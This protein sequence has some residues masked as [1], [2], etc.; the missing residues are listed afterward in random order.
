MERINFGCSV[1]NIP[2]PKN[3]EYL[4]RLIDMTEKLIKRMRWRAHYFL[5]PSSSSE[6][7]QETFGFR[8][9]KSPPQIPELN[10]F[11]SKMASL[12]QNIEFK[13]DFRP[14]EFQKNL[15]DHTKAIGKDGKL[16]VPADKTTN[17]YTMEKKEYKGMLKKSIEKEYKKA[18]A[19]A[20]IEINKKA[21]VIAENLRIENRVEKL[22][23]K[24]RSLP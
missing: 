1:K 21:K 20:E 6:E 24:T 10:E 22:A 11:E 7:N 19:A 2:I 13:P 5:H 3:K 14:T 9:K 23:K 12:V 17:F 16:F 18:P 4:K 8:S 15:S